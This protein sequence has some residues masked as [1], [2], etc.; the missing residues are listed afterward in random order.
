MIHQ[1][2]CDGPEKPCHNVWSDLSIP[3]DSI[4]LR[5]GKGPQPVFWL[6]GTML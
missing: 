1:G 3:T 5:G 6:D 2:P 4:L